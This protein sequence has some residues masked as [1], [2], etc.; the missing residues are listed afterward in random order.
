MPSGK[1]GKPIIPEE[2]AK[3]FPD[4]QQ[5]IE[6][7]MN[8]YLSEIDDET[9]TE[10]DRDNVQIL[11]QFVVSAKRQTLG[12]AMRANDFS[13]QEQKSANES[14]RALSN[15]ARQLSAAL[16]I[17]RKS[18][19][20]GDQSELELTLP[21]IFAEAQEYI[22]EHSI[23]ICCLECRNSKAQIDIRSGM[24]LYHFFDEDPEWSATFK[25]MREECGNIFTINK[26]N[27][28]DY[29]MKTLDE[30]EPPEEEEEEEF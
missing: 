6:E 19:M 30:I 5:E 27:W 7:T 22:Y 10:M 18:R 9:L 16:G 28:T 23:A 2:I 12:I 8:R 17:D 15:E 25:C 29:R 3:L 20:T 24:L 14:A 13:P 21:K 1:K 11:A 26:D 4:L